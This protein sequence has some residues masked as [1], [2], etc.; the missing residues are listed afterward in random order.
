[1]CIYYVLDRQERSVK[2]YA[3]GAEFF[4]GSDSP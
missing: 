1:M 4:Y 2:G 3:G